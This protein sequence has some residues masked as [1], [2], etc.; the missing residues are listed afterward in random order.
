MAV[1][2]RD[3]AA[4]QHLGVAELQR[5]AEREN[6]DTTGKRKKD[7]IIRL[8]LQAYPSGVP[9]RPTPGPPEFRKRAKRE[10]DDDENIA[11]VRESKRQ[12]TTETAVHVQPRAI[13]NAPTITRR[14]ATPSA[15]TRNSKKTAQFL[16]R[17]DLRVEIP[18][19]VPH[20]PP[21]SHKPVKTGPDDKDV[22]Y[23]QRQLAVLL[24]NK[25]VI[26][27]EI[28][29]EEEMLKHVGKLTNQVLRVT[30]EITARR[31]SVEDA[32]GRMRE[33]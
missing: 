15:N 18:T 26:K 10:Y 21:K 29:Q 3:E 28:A 1:A 4:L 12:R 23:V 24:R 17:Q 27:S 16:D 14:T 20:E 7:D 13:S 8:L 30:R 22:R 25:L 6:I 19:T 9:R 32:L 33:A 31:L 11:R 5:I 2:T